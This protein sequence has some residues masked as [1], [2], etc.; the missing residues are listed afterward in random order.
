MSSLVRTA[1]QYRVCYPHLHTRT[2]CSM[3]QIRQ[4]DS[5]VPRWT[6]LKLTSIICNWCTCQSASIRTAALRATLLFSY[7]STLHCTGY[8]FF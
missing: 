6:T 3:I 8:S 7:L 2:V 1:V 5:T 4:Y